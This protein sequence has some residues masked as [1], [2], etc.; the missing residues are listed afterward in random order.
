MNFKDVELLSAYLDGQTSP[1]DSTRLESRL[2]TDPEL[3]SA[4]QALRESRGLLRRLPKRRAP[5]DFRLT[6]AMVGKKPPL[7]RSYPVFRFATALAA[8]LFVFSYVTNGV[9]QLAAQSAPMAYG[10]G[11]GAPESRPQSGGGME[12]PAATEPPIVAMAPAATEAPVE[13]PASTEAFESTLAEPT[14]TPGVATDQARVAETP[15]AKDPN[16][17]DTSPAPEP[18]P[19]ATPFQIPTPVQTTVGVVALLGL[20]SML[21]FQRLAARK[22][23]G[24]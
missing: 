5:R 18:V 6:Y 12:E 13:E 24:K 9:S 21:I 10:I 3:A 7:P 14:A 19:Q 8:I 22:W 1:S 23:R 4:Y 17:M 16:A 15:M 11:G 2:K 20:A